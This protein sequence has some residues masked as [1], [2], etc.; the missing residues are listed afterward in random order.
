MGNDTNPTNR[1]NKIII[2][3]VAL[4]IVH[5][6]SYLSVTCKRNKRSDC[7]LPEVRCT[8]HWVR[9]DFIESLIKLESWL[10][11]DRHDILHKDFSMDWIYERD[12]VLHFCDSGDDAD[13]GVGV[14]RGVRLQGFSPHKP[15]QFHLAAATCWLWH[16]SRWS[17]SADILWLHFAVLS[18]L[19]SI[20]T[21]TEPLPPQ[22]ITAFLICCLFLLVCLFFNLYL[23]ISTPL[24]HRYL[25][26]FAF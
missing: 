23:S 1:T 10:F 3:T 12:R 2:C 8:S 22:H 15:F 18:T 19:C 11:S 26:I 24:S 4:N 13:N 20:L 25:S 7:I 6:T 14:G 17:E 21:I 5:N 9:L 16:W